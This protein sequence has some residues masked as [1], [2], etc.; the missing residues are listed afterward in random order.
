MREGDV[1]LGLSGDNSIQNNS[2]SPPPPLLRLRCDNSLISFYA[3]FSF[4]PLIYTSVQF[5]HLLCLFFFFL[6]PIK[7]SHLFITNLELY[8]IG[9]QAKEALKKSCKKIR[10][11]MHYVNN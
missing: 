5:F 1:G 6:P 4:Y 8:T 10:P 9:L 2:S 3:L 7:R 11:P